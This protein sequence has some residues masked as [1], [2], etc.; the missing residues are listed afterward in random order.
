MSWFQ[1]EHYEEDEPGEEEILG[2]SFCMSRNAELLEFPDTEASFMPENMD[3]SQMAFRFK[4]VR[5]DT[6]ILFD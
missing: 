5:L 3:S 1:E 2:S 4:E 6:S